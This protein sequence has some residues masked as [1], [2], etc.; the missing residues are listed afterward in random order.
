MEG[1]A[2]VTALTG[3]GP[4]VAEKLERIGVFCVR[5]LLLH[6]PLRYEDRTRYVDLARL[7]AGEPAL[8]HGEIVEARVLFG[9]RRSL[10]LTLY[11]GSGYLRVRFFHFSRRQQDDLQAGAR[12]RGFG[13]PRWQRDG[14]E[15]VHPDYRMIGAQL[16]P[17]DGE[18]APV[19]PTTEGLGQARLQRLIGQALEIGWDGFELDALPSI[20]AAIELLHAP[21]P[22]IDEAALEAARDRVAVDELLAHHL[23]LRERQAVR[24][25]ERTRPLGQAGGLGR[26]L[27][28]RLGFELTGAQKRCLREIFADLDREIPM[29]RLVQGDVGS[30]KTILAAF[31]AIRA[32][33][34]GAQTA[35]L[36]PTE[37]LAEQHYLNFVDWLAPLGIEVTLLTGR[38]GAADQRA[39]RQAIAEGRTQ[40]AIGTHALF[41]R[42]VEFA[43]LALVII[44]EQHRFGVHQRLRL[45]HKGSLPHQLVMTATPIPRTL[46][47]AFYADLD[48]SVIDELPPGRQTI[49]TR[50]LPDTRR[51]EVVEWL[52]ERLAR[53]DQAYWVTSLIEPGEDTSLVSAEAHSEWLRE[54]LPGV[55]TATLH[56]RLHANDKQAI[57]ASFKAGEIALLVATT[58]VE[59]GVDVPNASV[60][61]IENAERFGLAQLHQLRGRVGRGSRKSFCV[62]LH[63]GTPGEHASAR[64][65]VMRETN[66]GFRIAE[67]DLEIRGP[68]DVLGT[69]QTGEQ[70]FRIADPLRDAPLLGQVRSLGDRLLADQPDAVRALLA[71][72]AS[73]E[74]GYGS[75]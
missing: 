23:L 53:G 28:R 35:V 27:H 15:V 73:I 52:A 36:A 48:V 42:S 74:R 44:D 61:V 11:D 51:E 31:A 13:E 5:D 30:G 7:Q 69:R 41:Q 65:D 3:V 63:A 58:V 26:E 32:T 12:L 39:A 14:L 9:R 50:V 24:E 17:P 64:L 22:D 6:L 10:L 18:L 71:T 2:P 40:V 70:R 37:I 25:R 66:D 60:M 43:E 62:L 75:V 57:M 19:Y 59:V 56:G 29:L 55:S 45:R 68:G 8:F 33:E 38:L 46:T 54:V 67:R 20:A 4:K 49:E 16:P 1:T 21:P 72:W 47:M 34:H